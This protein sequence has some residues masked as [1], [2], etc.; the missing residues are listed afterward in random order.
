[1]AG[2]YNVSIIAGQTHVIFEVSVVDDTL[3]EGNESFTLEIVPTSLPDKIMIRNPDRT[4]ITI[5]DNDG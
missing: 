3:H 5:V 2:P 4:S 1:M